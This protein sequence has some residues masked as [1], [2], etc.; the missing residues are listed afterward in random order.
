MRNSA[1]DWIKAIGILSV[2]FIHCLPS[3]LDPGVSGVDIWLHS[4]TG[5]AVP[6]F[7]FASGFLYAS[8]RDQPWRVMLGRRLK[9]LLIPYLVFS[10]LTYV[11]PVSTFS[12]RTTWINESLLGSGL[13]TSWA[14]VLDSLAFGSAL[15]PYYYVFVI[16]WLTLA[17]PLIA[18][19]PRSMFP[20]FVVG[21]IVIGWG[22]TGLYWGLY[23]FFWWIRNPLHWLCFFAVGWWA[24]LHYERVIQWVGGGRS[25]WVLGV[26]S[27]WALCAF[28]LAIDQ[29]GLWSTFVRWVEIYLSIA[30]IFFATAGRKKS[31]RLIRW[32]SQASYSIYLS[33]LF[34]LNALLSLSWGGASA[35]IGARIA[36]VVMAWSGAM[37]GSTG[38]L[39]LSRLDLGERRARVWFG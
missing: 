23:S 38:L 28:Y 30:L 3:F 22:F 1:I 32:L 10:G 27:I 34:F 2:V 6:G 4:M 29:S 9:R 11:F 24:C 18:L 36:R 15:G 17:T 31:S 37:A 25:K 35:A 8:Q 16:F 13:D 26:G 19:I 39:V 12:T 20:F 14:S 5:F 33:H 7:L 21:S